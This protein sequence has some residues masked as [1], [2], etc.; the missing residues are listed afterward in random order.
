MSIAALCLLTGTTNAA[1][2]NISMGEEVKFPYGN[3][4]VMGSLGGET[5]KLG[6]MVGKGTA[7][8]ETILSQLLGIFGFDRPEYEGIPKAVIY[9]RFITNLL[10]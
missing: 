9:I 7:A 8:D 3:T 1:L 6:E 4:S 2:G 10:L 5:E